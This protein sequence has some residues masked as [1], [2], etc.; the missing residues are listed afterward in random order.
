MRQVTKIFLL[1]AAVWLGLL[2]SAGAFA[3]IG[4]NAFDGDAWQVITIGYPGFGPKNL[5]EEYRRN[6]PVIYYTFDQTFLDYFGTAGMV[7]INKAFNLLNTTFTNSPSGPIRGIDGYSANLAEF[8]L[9]SRHINYQAQALGVWS[10]ES[11]L[12]YLLTMQLGL[13]DPVFSAWGL[14]DRYLPPGATCPEGME[15]LVDERNFDY[16]SSPLNQ[17][18]YSPYVNDTLYSYEIFE[19]CTPGPILAQTVPYSVDPLADIYSPVA[20][21][22]I[23]WG[24]FYSG[25]TRDDAAGL[26]YLMSSN[27]VNFEQ[28]TLDSL[29]YLETTNMAPE[30]FPPYVNTTTNLIGTNSGYYVFFGSTTNG[31]FGYGNLTAFYAFIATN[32]PAAVEAAYPGV[33]ITSSNFSLTTVSNASYISYY[34]NAPYGSPYGSPPVLVVKTNYTKVYEV[35]WYYTFANVFT[36]L[37]INHSASG[38][39]E[40]VTVT[41]AAP[42]GSPYGSGVVTNTTVRKLPTRSADFFVFTQFFTNYC[43]PDF[44]TPTNPIV[45][46]YATTNLVSLALT[47]LPTLTNSVFSTNLTSY[48]Y[49]VSFFTNYSY[50]INPVTCEILIGATNNYQGIE[51]VQFVYVPYTNF[52]TYSAVLTEP[53]T[54]NYNL[55]AVNNG[56]MQ[57][58]HFQ[59]IVTTPDFVIAAVD[60]TAGPAAVPINPVVTNLI[61]FDI[62]AVL[63]GLAGPGTIMSWSRIAWNK[64][65]P[66]YYNTPAFGMDGTPYFTETPGNDLDGDAFYDVYFVLGDFDGTT[67]APTVFP[68]GTTIDNLEHQVLIQ[69]SPLS[70]ANGSLGQAYPPVQFSAVGGA[71]VGTL[72]WLGSNLPPGLLISS[73]GLLSGTPTATGTY[74]F[75]IE[76]TDS[77]GLSVQWNYTMMIQ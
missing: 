37:P 35:L 31:G 20:S 71:L 74:D 19:E 65:G 59:R 56:V 58:Q 52:D 11:E 6:T 54:N 8:P 49:L 50:E 60:A 39:N 22:A 36:N 27:N 77:N 32:P 5:G 9:E 13:M 16:I 7:P 61:Q 69:V 40:L 70:V 14:H 21:G 34:T 41:V 17:L 67:N 51:K 10:M 28:T 33:V 63:P 3:L 25:L 15:Y 57:V 38:Y 4:P 42:V 43:I 29:L 48:T 12:V 30:T 72:T 26:R 64:A 76:V 53:V 66:I 46:V 23:D 44:L 55:I 45:G 2:Q 62:S 1:I 68:N 18:Q 73:S 75:S 47:N 24:V